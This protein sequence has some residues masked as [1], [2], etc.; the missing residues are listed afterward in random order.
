MLM[1][2]CQGSYNED[3]YLAFTISVLSTSPEFSRSLINVF[4]NKNNTLTLLKN[5]QKTHMSW[6]LLLFYFLSGHSHNEVIY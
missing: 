5:K 6:V 2:P 3:Q 1:L 4:N